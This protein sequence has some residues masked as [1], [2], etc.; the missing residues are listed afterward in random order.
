MLFFLD[1]TKVNS[2]CGESIGERESRGE[3]ESIEGRE[4]SGESENR[5]ST[6][7]PT[8]DKQGKK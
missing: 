2:F 8:K 1:H 4:S 6:S 3:R 7:T 5:E